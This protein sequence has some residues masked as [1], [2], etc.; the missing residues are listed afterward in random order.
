M[1]GEMFRYKRK[2]TFM[3]RAH[4]EWKHDIVYN[5]K[6]HDD[7]YVCTDLLYDFKCHGDLYGMFDL[8]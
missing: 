7:H 8:V 5:P 1:T 4:E 2:I 6:G 3:K